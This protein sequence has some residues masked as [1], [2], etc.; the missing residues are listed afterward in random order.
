MNLV[1]VTIVTLFISDYYFMLPVTVTKITKKQVPDAVQLEDY[2][3][4]GNRQSRRKR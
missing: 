3:D 4:K 2:K 1:P